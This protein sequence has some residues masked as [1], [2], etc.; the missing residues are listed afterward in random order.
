MADWLQLNPSKLSRV[1]P[2]DISGVSVSVSPSPYDLPR[3]VRGSF[4]ES[5]RKFVV[6]FKYLIEGEP[7]ELN[8]VDKSTET[9]V[10]KHSGRLYGIHVNVGTMD[11]VQLELLTKSV[12]AEIEKAIGQLSA[13]PSRS[14]RELNYEIARE[15][16]TENEPKLFSELLPA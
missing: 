8:F 2:E 10:G 5:T 6:E 9:K 16:V 12:V 1:R 4:D 13:D 14:R 15:V 3:A 11:R 7:T